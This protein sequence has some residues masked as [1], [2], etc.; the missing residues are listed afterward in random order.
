MTANI[1]MRGVQ[2]GVEDSAKKVREVGRKAVLAYLG[3]W[4]MSYD[5]GKS[6]YN[7]GWSWV[8]K[9]EK[10]GEKVEKEL[11]KYLKAYQQDF[12]GEVKKLAH[13]VEENV[14]EMAK[15]MSSQADKL[16]KNLEKYVTKYVRTSGVSEAV[17][18]IKV[19]GKSVKAAVAEVAEKAQEA[20]ESAVDSVWAGY[21]NLSVK[22]I[23]AGLE[24]KTLADLEVL[25][26]HE[27]GGKNRVTVLREIDARL[28]AMTS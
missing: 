18:E 6:V 11:L 17:E 5:L 10:R 28:Q 24:S 20:V 7:D 16:G 1:N 13:T 9:A 14:T 15:D 2:E 22:D 26:E 12:P 4:G 25:R 21:D 23:L 8:D 19:N 3:V 27:V